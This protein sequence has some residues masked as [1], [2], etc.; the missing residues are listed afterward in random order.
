MIPPCEFCI[1]DW[2]ALE[3][4]D[5]A[6]SPSNK[7]EESEVTDG[8]GT[9]APPGDVEYQWDVH[10]TTVISPDP[11]W[12]FEQ[13]LRGDIAEDHGEERARD[14]KHTGEKPAVAR[15]KEGGEP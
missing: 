11:A 15:G 5:A 13:D 10:S 9:D 3:P 12:D 14:V 1:Y 7:P 6:P 8:C 2:L 4:E